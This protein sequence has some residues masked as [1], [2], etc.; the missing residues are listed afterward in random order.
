MCHRLPRGP[1]LQLWKWQYLG[2]LQT[3][4]LTV[5]QAVCQTDVLRPPGKGPLPQQQGKAYSTG[6][7]ALC[8]SLNPTSRWLLC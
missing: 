7:L 4:S 2:G 8:I 1:G 5:S 6:G 3:P